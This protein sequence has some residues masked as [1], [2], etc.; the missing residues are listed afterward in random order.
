MNQ[1]TDKAELPD[2]KCLVLGGDLTEAVW[3]SNGQPI[4]LEDLPITDQLRTRLD[5]WIRLTD[6]FEYYLPKKDRTPFDL[7]GF[8]ATGL[9]IAKDLKGELPD[10]TILYC[11][12][13]LWQNRDDLFLAD[14]DCRYEVTKDTPAQPR[15]PRKAPGRKGSIHSSEHQINRELQTPRRE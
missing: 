8:A 10:W 6:D 12:E 11:D 13:W 2:D 15:T 3:T 1:I 9:T 14:D 7:K 4:L 5:K